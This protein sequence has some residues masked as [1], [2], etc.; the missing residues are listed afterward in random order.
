MILYA[1]GTMQVEP[2]LFL[3]IK[4]SEVV[5]CISLASQTLC[6]CDLH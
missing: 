4:T 1:D 2:H 3:D 6:D 5:Q